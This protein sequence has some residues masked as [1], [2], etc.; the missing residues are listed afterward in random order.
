MARAKRN[1]LKY[2]IRRR[3]KITYA[4]ITNNPKRR[5]AE[6]KRA[7]KRG[8]LRIE[9]RRVSRSSARKWERTTIENYRRRNGRGSLSNRA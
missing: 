8:K 1:T 3:N 4:G 6:H 7:G 5:A 2:T 9:G